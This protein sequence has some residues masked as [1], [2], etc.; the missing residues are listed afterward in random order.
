MHDGAGTYPRGQREVY[1]LYVCFF[2]QGEHVFTAPQNPQLR[3]KEAPI[4]VLEQLDSI[5]LS[6]PEFEILNQKHRTER[7]CEFSLHSLI[8]YLNCLAR[9]CDMPT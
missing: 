3:R 2:G 8:H 5:T 4:Q 6:A 1:D 7:W 9:A